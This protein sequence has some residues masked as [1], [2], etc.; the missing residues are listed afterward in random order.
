MILIKQKFLFGHCWYAAGHLE[1][2]SYQQPLL[3]WAAIQILA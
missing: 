1:R 3:S 2:H